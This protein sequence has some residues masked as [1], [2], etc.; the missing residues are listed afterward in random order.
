[1]KYSPEHRE[2]ESDQV[3][4]YR[5]SGCTI[6]G[7][8]FLHDCSGK[9]STSFFGLQADAAGPHGTGLGLA[10]VAHVIGHNGLRARRQR[11]GPRRRVHAHFPLACREQR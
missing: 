8:G 2:D 4:R 1:M 11:G 7:S 3:D 9:S 5:S 10:I 6:A